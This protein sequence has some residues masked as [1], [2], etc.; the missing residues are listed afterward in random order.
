MESFHATYRHIIQ[1]VPSEQ[2]W[3]NPNYIRTEAPIIKRPIGRPKVHNR[4][5]EPVEDLIEDGKLKR[6]FR[7]TCA[8]C[9]EKGHNYKTCKGP[10]SNPSWKPKTRKPK[11]SSQVEVPLTQSAPQSQ[12]E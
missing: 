4:R 12:P 1:P 11:A 3:S 6:I 5:R 9:G 7:I 8:K 10:A 2:Y